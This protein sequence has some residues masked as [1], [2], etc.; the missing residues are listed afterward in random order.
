MFGKV[1]IANRG[2]IAMRI[3]RACREMGIRTVAVHSTADADAMHVRLADEAVCIGPPPAT[4]SYLNI[5]ALIAAAEV[6]GADAVH[7][8]YGFLAENARFAEIVRAHGVVFIGPDPEHIRLMGDKLAARNEMRTRGL[9]LVP[10]SDGP[11]ENGAEARD[12][13]AAI[14][15]P[16]LVKASAGGGGRGMKV[17]RS[18]G[19]LAEALDLAAGE[20]PGD[21]PQARLRER[22]QDPARRVDPLLHVE[23]K[24]AGD[25]RGRLPER[26]VEE[27][28][29]G[30]PARPPDL[31]EVAEAPGREHRGAGAAPLE[32]GVRADG[33]PVHHPLDPGRPGGRLLQALEHR[34]GL[35]AAPGEGLGGGDPARRPVVHDDVGE[36]AADV[37]ADDPHSGAPALRPIGPSVRAPQ[38]IRARIRSTAS[39]VVSTSR[40]VWAIE[41]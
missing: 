18:P 34:G 40:S 20:V 32:D 7:P 21:R 4:E 1:L 39:R 31:E 11:V 15:Y 8:G 28:V 6:T 2:E 13:A 30:H 19:E 24:G 14:G 37:D 38:P 5:P 33:G 25:E 17:A 10:G 3:H 12:M 35:V 9:A 36:R 22:R 41:K 23:T 29:R 26:E 16:V 27:G